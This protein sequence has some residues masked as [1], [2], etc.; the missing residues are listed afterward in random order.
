MHFNWEN[1]KLNILH[2]LAIIAMLTFISGCSHKV[3]T[4]HNPNY[5]KKEFS[6]V[7]LQQYEKDIKFHVYRE[8]RDE[9]ELLGFEV[10]MGLDTTPTEKVDLIVTYEDKW[11]WDMSN[12]L[13]KLDV[14]LVDADEL[15]SISET[16]VL[17]TSLIRKDRKY[18]VR[19]AFSELFFT[20]ENKEKYLKANVRFNGSSKVSNIY[21]SSN[22]S[23][24]EYTKVIT[25]FFIEKNFNFLVSDL[26]Y[27][28]KEFNVI[29][30]IY[31]LRGKKYLQLRDREKNQLIA[32][33]FLENKMD[34]TKDR[35]LNKKIFNRLDKLVEAL[36][37]NLDS[38]PPYFYNYD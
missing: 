20:P 26:K 12:Y 8:I 10:L 32:E 18:V 17:R 21:L 38:N 14:F 34:K 25:D 16:S 23:S 1:R 35:K 27:P 9:L 30:N 2:M 28:P 36:T 5:T 31:S 19:E 24:K 7:Y 29:C 15:V 13:L 3:S 22:D 37:G 6:K 4:R 33:V 11:M